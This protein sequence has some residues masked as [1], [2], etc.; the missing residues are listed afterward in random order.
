MTKPLTRLQKDLLLEVI[1]NHLQSDMRRTIMRELPDAYNRWMGD[2]IVTS[3]IH[4]TH[5]DLIT[6]DTT[7]S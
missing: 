3:Q 7:K 1:K 2:T 5:V 4:S 6:V